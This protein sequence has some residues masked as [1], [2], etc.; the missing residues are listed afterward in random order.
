M[1]SSKKIGVLKLKFFV[2]WG[3]DETLNS[4]NVLAKKG[5]KSSE[6][7]ISTFLQFIIEKEG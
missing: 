7:Q 6:C 3:F 4:K 2:G 5:L 1:F